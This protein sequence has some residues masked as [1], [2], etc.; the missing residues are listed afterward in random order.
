MLNDELGK[1]LNEVVMAKLRC[2]SHICLEGLGKT[3]VMI[4]SVPAQN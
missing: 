1:I 3:T 2:C 4:A